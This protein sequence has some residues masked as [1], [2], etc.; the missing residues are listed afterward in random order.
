MLL[1][2]FKDIHFRG[3]K[4]LN[5]SLNHVKLKHNHIMYIT[6]TPHNK[7]QELIFGDKDPDP[8]THVP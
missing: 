1:N 2:I 8:K 7:Q 4:I 6:H 5:C 3:K